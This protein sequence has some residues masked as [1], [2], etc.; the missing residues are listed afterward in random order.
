MPRVKVR[1]PEKLLDEIDIWISEGRFMSRSDAIKTI[2]SVYNEMV[3]T[4][5]FLKMLSDRNDEARNK[6]GCLVPL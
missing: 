2:V 6:P 3:K 5:A 1:I 4:K